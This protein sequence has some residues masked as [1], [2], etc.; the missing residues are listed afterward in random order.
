MLKKT[1]L[2]LF[3]LIFIISIAKAADFT[4][5][6]LSNGQTVVV[7]ENH[8]NPIVTID[9]WIN[10]GSINETDSN[11]GVS[12]FLEHLFFKGT[13]QHPAG[14]FDRI[15]ESKGAI[16][17]AATSKDF[18]HY[19]ITLPSEYFDTALELH[20]DMLINPQIP[21]NELEK[22]RKVVLE[23]I[24]KDL[25]TPQKIVYENLN[26]MMYTYHPYKRKVIGTSD[27]IS[28]ITREDVLD[29]FNN[30]YSP[31]NMIT[32]IVGDVN[33][34]KVIEKVSQDFNTGF[35]KIPTTKYK[36]EHILNGQKRKIEY[37]DTQSGYMMIGFRGDNITG[38]D[39]YALDV[40]AQVLGGEGKSSKLYKDIKEQKGLAYTISA[41]NGSFRDDGIFYINANFNPQNSEK[42]EKAIFE[43]IKYIQK[44]GITEEDLVLA[45]KIIEQ[46]TYYS[47]ESTSNIASELGYI[48]T[49]TGNSDF[50]KNYVSNI[51]KVTSKDVQNVA[52]K[53]L[54]I[55]KSAVSLV[56]PKSMEN[57]VSSTN[58]K[59]SATK[60]SQS[61]ELTKYII[62]NN[63]TLIIN[64]NKNNDIIAMSIIAK[65]G[66][67]AEK[68]I[69]EGTLA[70][71]MFLK[72]TK[73]Y[74]AQELAQ[75][76]DE[77]GIKINASCSEDY[78][79]VNVQ[80]TTSQ[81]ELTME[82]LD[83][84]FNNIS[85]DDYALEGKKSE[86]LGKIRQQRDIPMKVALENYQTMIFENSVYSHTNKVLEKYLP[87]I[88]KTDIQSY[89]NRIFDSKNMVISINGNVNSN[90]MINSF[91]NIFSDKK[92]PK[93]N[94]S[95]YKVTK[96]TKAKIES[97]KIKELQ[98]SWLFLG[99]QT[100]GV[101]NQ[102]DFVT[103]KII[104]T[105]L[106]NGMSSRL[107]RN[108]REQDGLAYQ[109]GSS[110]T[111]K[112][113]GGSFVTYVGTNPNTL[114]YSRNKIKSEIEKL[115]MEFVSDT[116]LKDA[117]ERLKGSFII[118][119]ETNSEKATVTGLFETLGLGYDYL[120]TYVR[121][122]D[123]V[124]ASDIIRVSNKYFNNIY[125]DS[126]V[127]P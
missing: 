13:K 66:E 30:Y 65:G 4:I 122:I 124:S 96:L 99:W 95:D 87:S 27:V 127:I 39:T 36:K 77:N 56:L 84:I 18:T 70:A 62:D 80:T 26:S 8:S 33:T 93:F 41:E 42:L 47:R 86:I 88:N 57:Q 115:K 15:L 112:E 79:I 102:K 46:D 22:E 45:Q 123:E 91:G 2:T 90:D 78:F 81:I 85:F 7:Q 94:Y 104:N 109:L 38:K 44:Y 73:K 74:S 63:S 76:M 9:T 35:K 111:P 107:F 12:H 59:H 11:N 110:Y 116:E 72:G 118:A 20:S 105:I 49:L 50:Y 23:E 82:L 103:L 5:Q 21:R 51:K 126:S 37:T 55:N 16:V 6:K 32:L 54:G 43:E 3:V 52:Q 121:M 125:V 106:G 75:I 117:K 113:L 28:K 61:N 17:N 24:S 92:Q 120:E 108:L 25:N 97:E 71:G 1:I 53:Y 69:G 29:Y 19:Y 68:N 101:S 14:E 10:T 83:E 64:E 89:F 119:M 40:L 58:T 34:S 98:T 48:M 114:D 67:L 60:I 31:T 100:C